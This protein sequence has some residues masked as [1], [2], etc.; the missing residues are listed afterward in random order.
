VDL[1]N[2]SRTSFNNH[3]TQIKLILK[4]VFKIFNSKTNKFT[5]NFAN[6]T[7][8]TLILELKIAN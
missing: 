7:R 8:N 5:V 6:V 2:N 3:A 1:Q 4:T